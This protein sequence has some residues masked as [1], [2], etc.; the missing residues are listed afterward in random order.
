LVACDQTDG[1]G[2]QTASERGPRKSPAEVIQLGYGPATKGEYTCPH[3]V[4]DTGLA[5]RDLRTRRDQFQGFTRAYVTAP[6][7][8]GQRGEG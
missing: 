6:S 7:P 3:E 8:I 5:H 1:F 2:E 4:F